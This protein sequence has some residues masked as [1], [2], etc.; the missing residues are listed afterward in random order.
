MISCV[1]IREE[2]DA[3]GKDERRKNREPPLLSLVL[4]WVPSAPSTVPLSPM[5]FIHTGT[6]RLTYITKK[7]VVLLNLQ[8]FF[9][10]KVMLSNEF[11][12]LWIL[13]FVFDWSHYEGFWCS[14]SVK[15]TKVG[16]QIIHINQ[17]SVFDVFCF[18]FSFA[19]ASLGHCQFHRLSRLKYVSNYLNLSS[20]SLRS[21]CDSIKTWH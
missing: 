5:L 1:S 11:H 16:L 7:N 20:Q 2:R 3:A 19:W 21:N 9:I 4:T 15:E 12:K 18:F 6:Y 14:F 13:T 8:L 17:V 10:F